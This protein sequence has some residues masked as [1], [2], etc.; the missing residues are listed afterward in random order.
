M[1]KEDQKSLKWRLAKAP[2]REDVTTM[3]DKG[4]IT[5]EEAKELLFNLTDEKEE[6]KVLKEQI[7]FL[8]GVIEKLS[9]NQPA[10]TVIQHVHDWRPHVMTVPY[11]PY[12]ISTTGGSGMLKSATYTSN[13]NDYGT[14]TLVSSV[15]GML[16]D[17][18]ALNITS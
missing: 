9:N 1:T 11:R 17:S 18:K 4:I 3:L 13:S 10:Q 14:T 5:K 8:K 16:G 7:E 2:T 15:A 6:N 12:W